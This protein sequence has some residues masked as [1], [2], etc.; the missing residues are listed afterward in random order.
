MKKMLALAA[1][2]PMAAL[3]ETGYYMVTTCNVE[4]QASIDYKYWTAHY[5]N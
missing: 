5:K 4:G 2:I 1:M 3:G